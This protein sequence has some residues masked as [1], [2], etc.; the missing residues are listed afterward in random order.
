MCKSLSL[1]PIILFLPLSLYSQ[2]HE[3]DVANQPLNVLPNGSLLIENFE[4][5][6]P[7]GLPKEWYNQKGTNKPHTYEG[8]L[9][10]TYNYEIQSSDDN[11]YLRF[12]GKRG[13]HL[14]FP[15]L[16]RPNLNIYQTPV[17]TWRWRVQNLPDGAREDDKDLNDSA[18]GIYVV[19]DMDKV[20]FKKVPRS[21]KYVWSSTLP[22]NE[23]VSNLFGRQK[24]VIVE[25]G[26]QNLGEW[27]SFSRNIVEDFKNLFGEN[28]PDKPI[29]ILILSDGDNTDS[30]VEA[31]Y[32]DIILKRP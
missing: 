10:D 20:L 28:P 18:A 9:R 8:D 11:K 6:K 27:R 29:A 30:M 14:N 21:I 23:V 1:L 19:F 5:Q 26:E 31:D 15:L 12:K 24:V 32:D 22:E 7:G 4:D 3:E 17:L 2:N 13:K 16:N 25:S